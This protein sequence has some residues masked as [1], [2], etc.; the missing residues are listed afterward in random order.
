M[1]S[2]IT[3][4]LLILLLLYGIACVISLRALFPRLIGSGK[5]L[6]LAILAAQLLLILIS[7]ARLDASGL[8]QSTW[9]LDE[10]GN[11]PSLLASTQ[12][13]LVAMVAL[14]TGW[15]ARGT[16]ALHRLYFLGIAIAFY[17]VARDEFFAYHEQQIGWELAY[18]AL[19][20]AMVVATVLAASWRP[21]LSW[22]WSICFLAGLALSAAGGLVIEQYRLPHTCGDIGLLLPEGCVSYIVEESLEMLGIW[23]AL[24]A[25]LGHYS[26]LASPSRLNRRRLLYLLPLLWIVPI[27]LPALVAVSAFRSQYESNA[28][29]YQSYLT[30]HIQEIE[31]DS[32]AVTLQ[33]LAILEMPGQ[34]SDYGYSLHLVDQ[35]SGASVA[36]IDERASRS[37]P[38]SMPSLAVGRAYEQSLTLDIAPEAPRNRALW[39]VLTTWRNQDDRFLSQKVI[40]SHYRLLDQTQ[41]IMGE[42][43]LPA[44]QSAILPAAVATFDKHFKLHAADYP[45]SASAGDLLSIA[46][47]WSSQVDSGEDFQQFLHFVHAE[48]GD[49]WGHDQRPLGDRLPTRLW[50]AGLTASEPWLIPLAADLAPGRYDIFTGLYRLHRV[51]R[52]QAVDAGGIPFLHARVPLGSIVISG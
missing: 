43:V 36:G 27:P 34:Y 47:S 49:W 5:R 51:E 16:S 46:F 14:L 20:A 28:L 7:L 17:Y 41:A 15:H 13:A 25:M 38:V 12:L 50:Y 39:I 29:R 33:F 11:I 10:E 26:Q 45:Q 23:L 8:E 42:F 21:R 37:H 22:R 6:A 44:Q 19:G 2:A 9:H 18:A 31:Y 35:A 52:L 1:H 3:V 40:Q 4:S 48:S 30:L 24:V 32:R